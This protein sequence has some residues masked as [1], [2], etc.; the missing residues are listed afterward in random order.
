MTGDSNRQGRYVFPSSDR[1]FLK[2]VDQLH[3]LKFRS[4]HPV[5][6]SSHNMPDNNHY[7]LI[8]IGSGEAGKV[9]A[10][11]YATT[12]NKRCAVIERSMLGGSCPNVAC[13][14]SKNLLYSAKA[15]SLASHGEQFGLSP[16]AGKID[17]RVVKL[18]KDKMVEGMAA[19]HRQNFER[20]G[21]ELIWGDGKFVGEKKIEVVGEGGE[22]RLVT[23]DYVLVNTGSRA[24][25][26]ENIPGLK[27]ADPLTHVGLLDLE[28][29]PR[30]LI[31][32][33]GGYV[34]LELAQAM[35]RLGAEVTVIERGNRILKNEDADV[36][37]VLQDILTKEGVVFQMY[38]N[39]KQVNG[40]SGDEV[41]LHL[42]TASGDTDLK[43][44]HIL[45]ATGRIPNTS[46]MGLDVAGVELRPTGHIIVD[47]HN[48]TSV[49]G[50]FASGD[51]AGRPYFTHVGFDDFRI[52]RDVFSGKPV[53]ANEKRKSNRQVPSTLFTDPEIAHVGLREQEAQAQ[54]IKY[55][56]TKTPMGAF[57]RTL[58]M[59]EGATEGFAKALISA[60]D[61]TIL[62][63]TA[64]GPHA[65]E[66]LPVVQLA[67]KKGL[68][69]TDVGELIITHP[70]MNESLS[71]VLFQNVPK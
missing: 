11:D 37:Q 49:P 66:L 2:F 59:E 29:L 68:P 35:R 71:M 19:T 17:Y 67:M 25:V 52:L 38:S 27:E 58:T 10:W 43:G 31:I 15:A 65:G 26:P 1:S 28:D 30:H 56:L 47:E 63:F 70:T 39:V 22:K 44:S 50:V 57:L 3:L 32:L 45:C 60:D 53:D 12:Q 40:I 36:A 48:R 62:G 14:P 20:S 54:G 9:L 55:R 23:A 8:S 33:G 42:K 61:D 16:S 24:R 18:R 69:Y 5:L 7:D 21:T 13:L 6:N 46:D 41:T 51:C 34:G 4:Y 64:I